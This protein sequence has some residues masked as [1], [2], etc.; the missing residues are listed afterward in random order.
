MEHREDAVA[1]KPLTDTDRLRMLGYDA[2]LGRPFGF[3]GLFGMN[4][5]NESILY[6]FLLGTS[7]YSYQAPLIFVSCPVFAMLPSDSR[8]SG[9]RSSSSS[10]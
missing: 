10:T 8:S 4:F 7:L 5:C 3:W 6:E 2:Q 1:D 9:I